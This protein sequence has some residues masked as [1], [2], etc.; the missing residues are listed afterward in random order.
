MVSVDKPFMYVIKKL[1]TSKITYLVLLAYQIVICFLS[2]MEVSLG[3]LIPQLM[4][5]LFIT[6]GFWLQIEPSIKYRELMEQVVEANYE[7]T[8]RLFRIK[9]VS[10]KTEGKYRVKVGLGALI[11]FSGIAL[12]AF[13]IISLDYVSNSFSIIMYNFV[14]LTRISGL[15]IFMGC[16]ALLITNIHFRKR[17][18]YHYT[19]DIGVNGLIGQVLLFSVILFIF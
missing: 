11:I 2:P 3:V 16:I 17:K 12:L 18:I 10:S 15:V 5:L 4:I 7:F 9:T 13:M 1:F 8:M 19:P 14:K 6:L